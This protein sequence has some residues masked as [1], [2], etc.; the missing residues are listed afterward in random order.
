MMKP[1]NWEVDAKGPLMAGGRQ[2]SRFM[3]WA[4]G[5]EPSPVLCHAAF[6]F[7][8][9]HRLDVPSSGLILAGTDLEGYAL[10][11]YEMHT[12]RI[13]RQYAVQLHG[14]VS[15][16]LRDINV[17][18]NDFIIGR[19]FVDADAGRPAETHVSLAFHTVRRL[20]WSSERYGL[21]CFAI[22]T[23]RRHQIR[24]HSQWEGHP[25]VTD[26]KYSHRK[27]FVNSLGLSAELAAAG[28]G[29]G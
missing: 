4:H 20:H 18:I 7:G 2:L 27:L 28:Y 23:G 6:E 11:Q 17:S 14:V 21:V 19:S 1:P 3:Q 25:T 22:Y 29:F 8:F 24:V 16:L 5:P 15:A 26:E 13:E 10:L 9:V 12:Y